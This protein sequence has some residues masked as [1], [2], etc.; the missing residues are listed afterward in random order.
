MMMAMEKKRITGTMKM[1]DVVHLDYLLLFV[2]DRFG[3]KLG[4]GDKTVEEVCNDYE[5]DVSFFI[6]IVN[7]FLDKDYVPHSDVST[8]PGHLAIQYLQNTHRYYLEEKVPEVENL[9]GQMVTNCQLDSRNIEILNN[10]F[11]VYKQELTSH[12][13]REEDGVFPY[14]LRISDAFQKGRISGELYNEMNNYDINDYASEHD[15]VEQKLYDLKNIIIKYLPPV[16]NSLLCHKILIELFNLEKDLNDHA[17]LEDKLIVPIIAEQERRLLE[18]YK[19][20][21]KY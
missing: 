6:E 17:L 8:F 10:F 18:L 14:V 3:I 11:N 1:A 9:I 2:L 15:N 19:A 4:F 20:G 5:V 21:Q 16:E 13:K 7:S 12:I